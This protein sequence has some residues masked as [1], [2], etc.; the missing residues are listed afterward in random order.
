MLYRIIFRLCVY[1]VY[2]KHKRISCLDLGPIPK[3][4]QGYEIFKN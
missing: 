3:I 2:I 1:M 4:T